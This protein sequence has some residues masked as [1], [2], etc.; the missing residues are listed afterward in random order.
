MSY[1]PNT[2]EGF[3]QTDVTV[4]YDTADGTTLYTFPAGT[5]ISRVYV[6]VTTTWN[7]ASPEFTV[8]DAS[9]NTGF[10]QDIGGSLG[11][12]GYY[13]LDHDNWGAYLWHAAGSHDLEHIYA[14]STAV[15]YYGDGNLDGGSQGVA[16][17]HFLWRTI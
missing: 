15:K 1:K 5:L 12:T 9:N 8:G 7:D 13:N 6:E 2:H 17:V 4:N 3:V 11:S 16:V 10:C 14:A